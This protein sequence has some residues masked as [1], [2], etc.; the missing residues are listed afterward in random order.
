MS[1]S[2]SQ[3][4][5]D[6]RSARK[7]SPINCHSDCITIS[8]RESLR[9]SMD[10]ASLLSRQIRKIGVIYMLT[11]ILLELANDLLLSPI[12]KKFPSDPAVVVVCP[13]T[14]LE[15]DLVRSLET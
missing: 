4:P 1:L 15:D 6:G 7:L 9:L 3:A 14:A 13:T 2:S 5:M 10:K 12:K 8:R 11:I